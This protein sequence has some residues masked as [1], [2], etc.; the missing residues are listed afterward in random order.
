MLRSVPSAP[1]DDAGRDRRVLIAED[2]PDLGRMLAALLRSWGREPVLVPDG[3]AAIAAMTG[4]HAPPRAVID[5]MM[6]GATGMDVLRAHRAR[7]GKSHVVML[8]AR[9][10]K[11]EIVQALEAGADDYL[12]KPFD[13]AELRARLLRIPRAPSVSEPPL[14][15]G[16]VVGGRYRLEKVL[17][18]GGMGA[19]WR[20]THVE[21]GHSVAIKLI[22]PVHAGSPSARARFEAEAKMAS[23]LR[24][25]YLVSIFDY[26]ITP[27]GT[28]YLVMEHLIG[29]NLRETIEHEGP[30]ALPLVAAL[31]SQLARGLETAH[32]AGVVHRDVKPENVFLED[33][34]GDSFLGAPF[35]AKLLDFGIARALTAPEGDRKTVENGFVGTLGYASPEQIT[36]EATPSADTW[37]LGATLL[38]AMT[39]RAPIRE[40]AGAAMMVATALGLIAL[41]SES[42]L[43]LPG[44]LDEWARRAL[45]VAPED[46][47][48]TPLAMARA[49]RPIVAGRHDASWMSVV[50]PPP[51]VAAPAALPGAPSPRAEEIAPAPS[52]A[53]PDGLAAEVTR[54]KRARGRSTSGRSDDGTSPGRPRARPRKSDASDAAAEPTARTAIAPTPS[55][56]ASI[57]PRQLT[58]CVAVVLTTFALAWTLAYLTLA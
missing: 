28:P 11:D 40:G 38:F 22:L 37:A 24:S 49:L 21:L 6:P 29:K 46:R 12:V 48:P 19:V 14:G 4:E 58:V 45:A 42:G 20:A 44:A 51:S 41:P 5:W 43:E 15:V 9:D 3:R 36:G 17:G 56:P 26:G 47:F 52:A 27:G 10:G 57:T 53:P 39:G 18:E 35:R 7:G 54:T 31:A 30:L 25:P 33:V 16:S 50:P 34:G 32:A 13:A 1:R 23:Q 8:T 2:D 55:A